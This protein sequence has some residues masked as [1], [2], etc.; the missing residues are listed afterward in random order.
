MT[1]EEKA[2]YELGLQKQAEIDAEA[3]NG[4][5]SP[6][7]VAVEIN[8][9]ASVD[10]MTEKDIPTKVAVLAFDAAYSGDIQKTASLLSYLG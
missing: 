4:A 3:T 10:D 8:K 5:L 9:I 7:Q 1:E 6:E 2:I